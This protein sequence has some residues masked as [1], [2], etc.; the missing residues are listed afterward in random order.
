MRY[1]QKD[2]V[3]LEVPTGIRHRSLERFGDRDVREG[4]FECPYKVSRYPPL[5]TFSTYTLCTCLFTE[6]M[7]EED[8][9]RCSR[10][11]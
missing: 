2:T 1:Y 3:K 7:A 6:R 10:Y 4:A 9:Q 5:G 8:E 11:L